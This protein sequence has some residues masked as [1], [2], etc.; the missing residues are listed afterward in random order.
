MD[1]SSIALKNIIEVKVDIEIFAFRF[2]VILYSDRDAYIRCL[3]RFMINTCVKKTKRT[4]IV[5]KIRRKFKMY[6][7]KTQTFL[8]KVWELIDFS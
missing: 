7:Q 5:K 6:R 4:C 3:L 1:W 8:Y 2:L